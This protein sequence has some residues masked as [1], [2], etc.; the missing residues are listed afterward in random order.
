[1]AWLRA[2][3]YQLGIILRV[4]EQESGVP[5]FEHGSTMPMEQLGARSRITPV[6]PRTRRGSALYAASCA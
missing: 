6:S 4:G 2:V 1:M 5:H 3:L